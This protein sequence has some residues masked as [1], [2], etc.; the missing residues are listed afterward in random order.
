MIKYSQAKQILAKYSGVGGKCATDE[1]VDLFV[2][3]VLQYLLYQGS[4]GNERKFCFHAVNGYV[5]LPKELEVP[6]KV[7]ID[8]EV[9]SVW[10][11][12]FE[13]HSGN[14]V[15]DP[16]LANNDILEEPN[17][18]PTVYDMPTC[19]GYPAVT[20]VCEEADDAHVIVKGVDLTGREIFSTH[21]GNKIVGVYLTIKK[22]QITTSAIKFGKITEVYKTPT[23]GYVTLLAMGESDCFR[24]FLSDYDPYEETPSYRRIRLLSCNYAT[25]RVSILGRIKLKDYYAD[26]DLIPFDNVYLLQVA[27]QTVNKMYNDDIQTALAKDQYV[28]GLIETEGNYKKVNNGQPVEMFR[29]LSGGAVMDAR[30]AGRR[31]YRGW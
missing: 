26:E 8:G 3:Q 14:D 17:R 7:K 2:K 9:K 27:G 23:K 28:K 5:T 18:F 13:Y 12:W 1:G 21:K 16:C 24:T 29:P 15:E 25:C 31:L 6:L 11:R 22:G 30:R 20:S 4:Y 10:N 19:G